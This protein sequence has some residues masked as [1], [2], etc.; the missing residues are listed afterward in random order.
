MISDRIEPSLLVPS[1][2]A[3]TLRVHVSGVELNRKKTRYRMKRRETGVGW[4]T[5]NVRI[6]FDLV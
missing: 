6:E 2:E 1:A 3:R 5:S 4:K